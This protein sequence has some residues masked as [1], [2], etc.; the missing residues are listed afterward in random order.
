[1]F[2]TDRK[3]QP[4]EGKAAKM[5]LWQR[6]SWGSKWDKSQ[7]SQMDLGFAFFALSQI[8]VRRNWRSSTSIN[9]NGDEVGI[10]P[11]PQ[12]KGL[13]GSQAAGL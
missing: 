8:L 13:G 3:T 11:H 7:G 6:L 1:M 10:Q 12:N 5:M 9:G 2:R 4:P